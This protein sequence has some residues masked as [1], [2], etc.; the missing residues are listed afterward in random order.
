M[1]RRLTLPDGTNLRRRD[2]FSIAE[3]NQISAEYRGR[4]LDERLL[5]NLGVRAPFFKRN[6]NNFCF[7]RDTFNALCTTSVPTDPDA[8]GLVSF[9]SSA[10]NSSAANEYGRPQRF[11]REYEELLPNVGVSYDLTDT[12]S[13]YASYARTISAPRTDDLYD[14]VP[15]NPDP[16]IA[17]AFDVGYRFQSGTFIAAA[18]VWY[19]KF[20]NRIERALDIENDIST[21]INIGSVNLMGV[22]GQIGFEPDREPAVYASPRTPTPKCRTA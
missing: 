7:Q 4:F 8:D 3:L 16:E 20:D 17:D 6:L 1:V 21:S 2:R 18:A 12:Q 19:N 13:V 10:L 14:R 22:D 5:V 11:E 15:A 9:P